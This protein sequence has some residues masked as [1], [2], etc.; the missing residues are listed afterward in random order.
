MEPQMEP[1]GKPLAYAYEGENQIK[2]N[3]QYTIQPNTKLVLS[4]HLHVS[5]A[6]FVGLI[7]LA[8]KSWR[9]HRFKLIYISVMCQSVHHY[10]GVGNMLLWSVLLSKLL[11]YIVEQWIIVVRTNTENSKYFFYTCV[12]KC[13]Y[14]FCSTVL[15]TM[16][17]A[18]KQNTTMH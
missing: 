16:I 13:I 18:V 11:M 1:N 3:P 10:S 6:V 2:S 9:N 14:V 7:L 8:V 17:H 4:C 12:I 5:H 15:E